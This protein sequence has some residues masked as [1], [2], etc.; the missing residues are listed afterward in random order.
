MASFV[1]VGGLIC[2]GS[3]AAEDCHPDAV[4]KNYDEDGQCARD[5]K[6]RF[7]GVSEGVTLFTREGWRQLLSENKFEIVDTLTELFVPPA[8]A[9]SDEEMHYFMIAQNAS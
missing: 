5:I 8:K 4:G 2:L 3:I 1:K 6:F 7:M 9:E